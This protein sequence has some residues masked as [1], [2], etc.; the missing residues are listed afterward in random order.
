MSSAAAGGSG[1]IMPLEQAI[2]AFVHPHDTVLAVYTEARPNAALLQLARTF[3]GSSPE[4]TLVSAGMV[5]VQHALVELGVVTRVIASF[6]G[7]NYPSARPNPAFQRAL[8][9]GRVT[10]ENWSMW[11]LLARLVAGGL[12]V[13]LM[14]VRSIAGSGMA[15]ANRGAFAEIAD[16]FSPGETV[17]TVAA[18]R[19]DIALVH[20]VAADA[21]GNLLLSAPYGEAQ[22]GC[23]AARRGVV[24][25]VEAIVDSDVIRA[26][27]ALVRVPGHLV[28]AVCPAPLGSHP[29]GLF[30][31]GVD[32]VEHYVDDA[33]FMRD[34]LTA[35]KDPD[36]FRSW[37][38]EWVL[39]VDSHEGYLERLGDERRRRLIDEARLAPPAPE[40]WEGPATPIERQVIAANRQIARRV[41][42]EG[43]QAILAGVGLSNLASWMAVDGM[44][45]AGVEVELMA[46]IGMYGYRPQPGDPFIFSHRNL[47]TSTMLTD[48]MTTLGALVAGPA[49]RSLGVLGAGEIDQQGNTASTYSGDGRYIV[50]SGGANDIASGA[51]EV[52][53]TVNHGRLVLS[54]GY[55]TSPG[56]RVRSIVSSRGVFER[57]GEGWVLRRWIAADGEDLDAAVA[58]MR[59][60]SPWEF[61]VDPHAEAEPEPTPAELALLRSYDPAKVFLRTR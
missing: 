22:W 17:A 28:R 18:L 47:P 13:G 61:T 56:A 31:P 4:L 8:D 27:N 30:N 14:P 34:V 20:A 16:P 40:P 32:G 11:G 24:A 5:S 38:D 49:T 53:L 41:T 42:S 48:V 57:A 3:A 36:A 1:K 7:E 23:L 54:L 12:G 33:A 10:V 46:E 19:P 25:T 29:Y 26:N 21:E 52:L 9:D 35:A 59:A 50:G 37:I 6:V 55:V 58:A 43:H 2:P 60:E 45:A 39:G 15:G 51:D 44:K